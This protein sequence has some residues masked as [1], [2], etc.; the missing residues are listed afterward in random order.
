MK[1]AELLE[2]VYRFYRRGLPE[3]DPT[4]DFTEEHRRLLEA[5]NRAR[6]EYAIWKAMIGRLHARY[7]LQNE[8]L[9]LLAGWTDPAYSARIYLPGETISLHVSLL[10]PYYGIH[11]LGTSD[12]VPA[13][14]AQEIEAAYPGYYPIPPELGNEVVPE[15]GVHSMLFGT[16]SIYICLLSSVWEWGGVREP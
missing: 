16:S 5:S 3:Y 4:Y 14:I 12:E 11:H 8:S 13:G 10:G 1:R 15:L 6:A 2:V 7:G 9:H